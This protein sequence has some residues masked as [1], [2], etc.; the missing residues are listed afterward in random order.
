M[1]DLSGKVAI[2]TGAGAGLGRSHAIAL[3]ERGAKVVVNDLGAAVDGSGSDSSRADLVVEEIRASGG[4]A[5]AEHS[6]VAT[7]EGGVAIV[8][9]ALDEWGQVDVLVNNAGNI[10]LSSFA[11]LDVSQIDR[12]LDVHLGGAFYVT[13]PAYR[14]MLPRKSG[15]IIFTASGVASFGNLGA[16]VYGAAKGGVLGL[17]SVLKLE[18]A[19]HGIRVNAIAPMAQTR[20]AA[21]AKLDEYSAVSE[22]AVGPDLCAPPVVY[23]ASD[24]CEL[25]GEVWSVGSGSVSRLFVGRAPGYFKNPDREGPLSPEDVAA[26]VDRIRDLEGYSLPPTWPEEWEMVLALFRDPA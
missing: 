3:A 24:E 17:L 21:D 18:A 19:R 12:L 26:N 4:E 14:A 6:S 15:S 16:G 2:V 13:Q 1:I 7:P 23:F 8:Q 25:T 22:D 20:M 5:V 9:R 10:E 11:K